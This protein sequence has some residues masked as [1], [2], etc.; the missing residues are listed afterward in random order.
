M[1]EG[2]RW[3]PWISCNLVWSSMENHSY[4]SQWFC[5]FIWLILNLSSWL[6]VLISF[7]WSVFHFSWI[8]SH[9]AVSSVQRV[10]DSFLFLCFGPVALAGLR[11]PN[12]RPLMFCSWSWSV[13]LGPCSDS[14]VFSIWFRSQFLCSQRVAFLLS[15][16]FCVLFFR[17]GAERPDIEL[18]SF[19][20]SPFCAQNHAGAEDSRS[21]TQC[22]RELGSIPGLCA[23]CRG[24]CS[25]EV[26]DFL[27]PP[28]F[29]FVGIS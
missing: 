22:S 8:F 12:L 2:G 27:L 28:R 6:P 11:F 25:H 21:C 24:V 29:P 14:S 10:K 16:L 7:A 26:S 23:C 1:R 9:V 3:H 15:D 19:S 4:W 13:L 17:S 20:R 18:S 5:V